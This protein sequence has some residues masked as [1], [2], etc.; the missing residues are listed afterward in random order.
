M[1]NWEGGIRGNGFVSGG[2]LPAE[3]RGTKYEE[4]NTV[5]DWYHTF[6]AFAG[7][8]PTDHRAAAAS[9]PP[10]DSFDMSAMIMGTNLTSPRTEIPIGTEPRQ[11]NIST[12]PLC[13]SYTAHQYY[14]DNR[15]EGDEI[16]PLAQNGKCTTVSG[17]IMDMGAG[18]PLWKILTGTIEQD[19]YSGPHFPNTST[20]VPSSAYVG[21]CGNGCLYD[22]RADPLETTDVAA[23]H[24]HILQQMRTKLEAYETTAFNPHR[25]TLNP[26]ACKKAL[27]EYGGF[28]GPFIE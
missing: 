9:L 3:R 16:P 1:N 7:V 23:S 20:T 26:N 22:I 14:E 11:S 15:I 10:I 28:W 8:D 18:K 19:C 12:A 13:S 21:H 5:W 24:P 17:L 25:G 4:L 2:F 27:G 6:S